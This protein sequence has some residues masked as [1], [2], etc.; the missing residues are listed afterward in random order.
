[1]DEP[2]YVAYYLDRPDDIRDAYKQTI[3]LLMWYNC[4]ANIEASRLSLL[5]YARDNKFMQYFMRRPRVC[6]GDN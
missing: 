2:K 4:Q 6:Y 3:G 1:M 5:T